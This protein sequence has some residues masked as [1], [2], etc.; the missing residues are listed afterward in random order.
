MTFM[1]TPEEKSSLIFGE[2]EIKESR[3]TTA[4]KKTSNRQKK[5]EKSNLR[6][7]ERKSEENPFFSLYKEQK[8]PPKSQKKAPSKVVKEKKQ[9]EGF[10]NAF[11]S[12]A[13]K[14]NCFFE[15][16][17]SPSRYKTKGIKDLKRSYSC[18]STRGRNYFKRCPLFRRRLKIKNKDHCSSHRRQ[19]QKNRITLF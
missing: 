14:E 9:E 15:A 13:K 5:V 18:P 16:V 1:E 8:S 6:D 11:N 10:F 2:L 19:G 17:L 12:D 7:K 3:H 4:T